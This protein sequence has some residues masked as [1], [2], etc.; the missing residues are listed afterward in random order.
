LIGGFTIGL[1]LAG[2]F[3]VRRTRESAVSDEQRPP[4]EAAASRPTGI[5]RSPTSQSESRRRRLTLGA[6]LAVAGLV[7][8]LIAFDFLRPNKAAQAGD[9]AAGNHLVRGHTGPVHNVRFLPDGQLVSGSGWPGGDR[10]V[11]VW[12]LVAGGQKKLF[13][14]PAQVHALDVSSDGRFALVGMG[15][16][17]IQY[18]DLEAV[19]PLRTMRGHTGEIGW[20]GFAP[21]AKHAFSASADGTA[22]MWDLEDGRE[23]Q[24]FT[25]VNPRARGGAVFPDGKRLLTGDGGGV[26]Q[27]WNIADGQELKR[28]ERAGFIDSLAILAEGKQALITGGGGAH[29]FDLDAGRDVRSFQE[30]S[31]E[32]HQAALSPDG[33]QLLT[34]GFDGVIRLWDFESGQLIRSLGNHDGFAFSVAFSPDGRWAASA[35]D[36]HSSG[37]DVVPGTDHDIRLWDLS[38]AAVTSTP[39]RWSPI[40][41]LVLLLA[42]AAGVA[43]LYVGRLRACSAL[44]PP[45]TATADKIHCPGCGKA[46]TV[47]PEWAGKKAKCPCGHIVV[48]PAAALKSNQ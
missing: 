21:D 24:R 38:G 29:L 33:K 36:A 2:W 28:I 34:A 43:I 11:R 10:T 23:Q 1:F 48:M 13:S 26:L 30:D 40:L 47:K 9:A 5:G 3:I 25:V 7:I 12:D 41:G 8:G 18:L 44:C 32:V 35:G 39:R 17:Q 31:E 42:A 20:V 15:N 19:R 22:R 16:G 6:I 45:A 27:I 4:G 46:F 14:L 37:G